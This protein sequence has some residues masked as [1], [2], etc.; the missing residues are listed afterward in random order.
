MNKFWNTEEFLRR[1]RLIAASLQG[2]ETGD[3]DLTAAVWLAAETDAELERVL[4][5][6]NF[7]YE[8]E[9]ALTAFAKDTKLVCEL[10]EEHLQ[11]RYEEAAF[12]RKIL[13]FGDVA[14]KLEAKNRVPPGEEENNRQLAENDTPLPNYLSLA[15]IKRLAARLKLQFKEKYWSP[16]FKEATFLTLRQSQQQAFATRAKREL[17]TKEKKD[18]S[19][20][21][22]TGK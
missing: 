21:K 22:T 7:D 6:I 1:R 5:E 13:T 3:A 4:D 18:E 20:K 15:E 9:F 17:K 14:K 11:T 10:A 19:G 12:E 16:F 8:S 2:L